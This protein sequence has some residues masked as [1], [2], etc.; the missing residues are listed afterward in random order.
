[1]AD[2]KDVTVRIVGENSDATR[3]LQAT[4]AQIQ[5]LRSGLGG[6]ATSGGS[7]VGMLGQLSSNLG[8][9]ALAMGVMGVAAFALKKGLTE[10]VQA[11]AESQESLQRLRGTLQ[12]LGLDS[13]VLSGRLEKTIQA[14]HAATR[15]DDEEI[16]AGLTNLIQLTGDV[17][18]SEKSLTAVADLAAARQLSFGEAANAVARAVEGQERALKAVGIIFT[19]NERKL[20]SYMTEAERFDVIQG[21]INE[22]FNG[23]R[24]RDMENWTAQAANLKNVWGDF[25]EDVGVPVV[26]VLTDVLRGMQKID[27]QWNKLSFNKDN[28]SLLK[29]LVG[30]ANGVPVVAPGGGGGWGGSEAGGPPPQQGPVRPGQVG[31]PGQVSASTLASIAAWQRM[32]ED[33]KNKTREWVSDLEK[34]KIT[35]A[36]LTRNVSIETEAIAQGLIRQGMDPAIARAEAFSR[37]VAYNRE[38]LNKNGDA[39]LALGV[40]LQGLAAKAVAAAAAMRSL[41]LPNLPFGRSFT[42]AMNKAYEQRTFGSIEEEKRGIEELARVQQGFSEQRMEWE[43]DAQLSNAKKVAAFYEQQV[44]GPLSD[45]F[46]DALITGG[47]NIGSIFERIFADAMKSAGGSLIDFLRD[48]LKDIFNLTPEVTFDAASGKWL[49]GGKGDY[50]SQD[51]ANTAA[52]TKGNANASG[53]LGAGLGAAA[54][55]YGAVQNRQQGAGAFQTMATTGMLGLQAGTALAT[56]G[57]AGSMAGPIG[58]AVGLIVGAIIS[59]MNDVQIAAVEKYAVPHVSGGQAGLSN[60]IG[61]SPQEQ[62]EWITKI[63]ASF[64]KFKNAYASIFLQLPDQLRDQ[65][66]PEVRKA[67]HDLNTGNMGSLAGFGREDPNNPQFWGTGTAEDPLRINPDYNPNA[68][69]GT[70]MGNRGPGNLV[71][72]A[73]NATDKPEDRTSPAEVQQWLNSWINSQLPQAEMEMFRPAF[74][75][76][77]GLMHVTT[78]KFE[79]IWTLAEGM[80]PQQALKY[81]EDYTVGLALL[82]EAFRNITAPVAWGNERGRSLYTAAMAENNRTFVDEMRDNEIALNEFAEGLQLLTGAEQAAG[83]RQLATMAQDY[84]EMQKAYALQLIQMV[85]A[86][87]NTL[88]QDILGLQMQGKD[89]LQQYDILKTHLA[90]LQG[91]FAGA[92]TAEDAQRIYEQIRQ[93]ILQLAGLAYSGDFSNKEE[94]NAWAQGELAQLFANYQ[95]MIA[96]FGAAVD[97]QNEAW[98]AQF[99]PLMDVFTSVTNTTTLNF[100]NAGTSV[101]VLDAAAASAATSITALD[102]AVV[103]LL[104]SIGAPGVVSNSESQG[105]P[106]SPAYSRGTSNTEEVNSWAQSNRA[107]VETG[108]AAWAQAPMSA[109]WSPETR[110]YYIFEGG[111]LDASVETGS[112]TLARQL[113]PLLHTFTFMTDSATRNFQNAGDTLGILN[114]AAEGTATSL[115]ALAAVADNVVAAFSNQGFVNSTR[116]ERGVAAE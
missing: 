64:E 47:K 110:S 14:I 74:E 105:Q 38:A 68:E 30:L 4:A 85:E 84:W 76:A 43:L 42:E 37:A 59:I 18:K 72:P 40:D 58:L 15:F 65:V 32:V 23:A 73:W 36:E 26:G 2:P 33:A 20:F 19:D 52:Q 25:V 106:A 48:G 82:Q 22:K 57:I 94:I 81:L 53:V 56:A 114:A 116:R 103:K 44:K 96:S 11:G 17:E 83:I 61:L 113:Q 107:S 8:S 34:L 80:N 51:A 67:L 97:A 115:T 13:E 66:M 10:I 5:G 98:R 49:V 71:F 35:L 75:K 78:E 69:G 41:S 100:S 102:G 12:G 31:A 89:P 3:K 87:K 7:T 70:T 77:F 101:A 24:T 9:G 108:N 93:T 39:A 60:V 62:R 104:S 55:I 6:L 45:I 109:G 50:L 27:E 29:W 46:A 111:G 16:R 99:Q 21:R 54:G 112:S 63:Q 92:T 86:A 91:Q 88:E 95:T 1:M 79:E 90:D 28:G